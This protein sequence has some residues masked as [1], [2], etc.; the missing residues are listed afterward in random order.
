MYEHQSAIIIII[1]IIK[2]I[3]GISSATA[4][5]SEARRPNMFIED[6]KI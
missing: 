5:T 6:R 2:I 3:Y 1:I 4:Q